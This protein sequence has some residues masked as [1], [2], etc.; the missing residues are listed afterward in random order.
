MLVV[1]LGVISS[2]AFANVAE[3]KAKASSD[4]KIA[5]AI[6]Q[7]NTACGSKITATIDWSKYDSLD[8]GSTPKESAYKWA[9]GYSSIALKALVS[10]CSDAAYKAEVAKVSNYV[11]QPDGTT[12]AVALDKKGST[13]NAHYKPFGSNDIDIDKSVKALF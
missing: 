10:L 12:D 2:N 9:G 7:V 11:A 8:Y 1:C 3:T 5:A 4:Q 13:I 6:A